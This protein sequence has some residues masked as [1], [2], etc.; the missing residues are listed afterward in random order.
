MYSPSVVTR[1]IVL[2]SPATSSMYTTLAQCM[3]HFIYTVFHKHAPSPLFPSSDPNQNELLITMVAGCF[4]T[5]NDI[6]G[7]EIKYKFIYSHLVF[8]P[9]TWKKK[10]GGVLS[11]YGQRSF[12]INFYKII[13]ISMQSKIYWLT[14]PLFI[15]VMND[16]REPM[17]YMTNPRFMMLKFFWGRGG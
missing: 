13:Y 5:K 1:H 14:P 10:G 8:Y 2:W 12:C 15:A 6:V 11:D 16:L 4:G 3:F 7:I 17:Q 9:G